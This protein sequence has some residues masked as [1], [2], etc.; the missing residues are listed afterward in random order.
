M[1]SARLERYPTKLN[2]FDGGKSV[3]RAGAA[4][5]AM[6]EHRAS[7]ATNPGS[8]F[9]PPQAGSFCAVASLR[10]FAGFQNLE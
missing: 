3:F 4:S 2:Q 5:S 9:A 1:T 8:R 6:P 10:I 7:V